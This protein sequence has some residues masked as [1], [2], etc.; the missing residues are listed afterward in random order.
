MGVVVAE[1]EGGGGVGAVLGTVDAN[2]AAG[3]IG[4]TGVAVDAVGDASGVLTASRGSVKT[5]TGGV[6]L[7]GGGGGGRTPLVSPED[8]AVSWRV[9]R[10]STGI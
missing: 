5:T 1:T 4:K 7:Y 3:V 8:A 10:V 9:A 6:C 2:M